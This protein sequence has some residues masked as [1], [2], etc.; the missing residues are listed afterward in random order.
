MDGSLDEAGF[1]EQM[2]WLAGRGLT[3][4]VVLGSTGEAP[5]ME[6]PERR[7][8][9]ATAAANREPGTFVIAGIGVE[10]TR[11]TIRLADDAA[12]AGADAVLVVN[13][14]YYRSAMTPRALFDHYTAVA[15]ASPLPVI[16][17]SI[18]QNTGLALEPDLVA[19]LSAHPGIIGLKDSGG[20]L[21][22]L[23]L[24]LQRTPPE[25]SIITGAAT[26][27]GP[28]AMAGASAAILAMA[29]VVP[30]LCVDVFA[31]GL[32]GEMEVMRD[33]QAQLGFLTRSI[34]GRYGIAGMKAA[35]DLLGG[36]GGEPRA[37]LTPVGDEDRAAILAS[38]REGGIEIPSRE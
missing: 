28:A 37:P 31:A 35:V 17:Y 10:S 20:D 19:E 22:D 7:R 38:L 16:L 34:Q 4:V 1:V 30:E 12:A 24:H 5:F 25:F 9:I 33:L 6:P 13:P 21:R 32:E 2:S 27:A 14:G 15:G 3:G 18:P 11:L 36:T 8:I 26:I 29:N 23:Q